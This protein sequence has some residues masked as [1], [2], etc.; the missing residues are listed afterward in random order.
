MLRSFCY[1]CPSPLIVLSA[2]VLIVNIYTFK[3]NKKTFGIITAA[4]LLI[5]GLVV[6]LISCGRKDDAQTTAKLSTKEGLSEYLQSMGYTPDT[7]RYQF[8]QVVIPTDFDEVYQKYNDL[9]KESGFDLVKYKGKTVGL[10]TF[11]LLNYE[12]AEDVL[13][14][15]L[16]YKDKVIGGSVYTADVS[17]FMHPLRTN[18]Q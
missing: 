5:L 3:L 4:V 15:L 18:K 17:G 9:Q 11:G 2:E 14:D 7:E 8:R 1:I 6:T 16:V 13:C 10:H 12:G